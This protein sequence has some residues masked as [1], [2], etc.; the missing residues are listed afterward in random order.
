MIQLVFF[1]L[2]I[3]AG[4]AYSAWVFHGAGRCA[5]LAMSALA[6]IGLSYLAGY[7]SGRQSAFHDLGRFRGVVIRARDP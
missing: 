7:A 3:T 1:L 6:L 4:G 5:G 2:G